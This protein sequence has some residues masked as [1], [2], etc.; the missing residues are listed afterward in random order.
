[1]FKNLIRNQNKLLDE[2]KKMNEIHRKN[3][4]VKIIWT[5]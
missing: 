3:I 1:M 2:G 4:L 5:I